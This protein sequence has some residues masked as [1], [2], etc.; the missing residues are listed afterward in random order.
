VTAKKLA[1]SDFVTGE[2]FRASFSP[3]AR[4][5]I[6]AR[7]KQLIA[8]ELTLRDLRKAQDLT[9]EEIGSVLNISQ[10]QVSRLEKRSDMLLSTLG[11]YV[12]AMGGELNLVV[13]F[14]GRPPV[15]VSSLTDTPTPPHPKP[16]RG[17]K[18]AERKLG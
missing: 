9:Q 18:M 11:S 16:R 15:T 4:A 5:R 8:E 13:Q 14:P 2:A 12:K 7:A 10:D 3:E 17:R 6:D 1:K